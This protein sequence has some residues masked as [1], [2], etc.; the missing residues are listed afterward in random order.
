MTTWR[1][2]VRYKAP[3]YEIVEFYEGEYGEG[4]GW[5]DKAVAPIGETELEL[6]QDLRNMLRAFEEPV[7][8]TGGK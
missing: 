2:R 7:I 6:I 1:Y 4:D 5:T 8:E 3:F